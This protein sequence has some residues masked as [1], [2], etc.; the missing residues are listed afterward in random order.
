MATVEQLTSIAKQQIGNGG[1]KYRKWFYNRDTDYYGVNWCAVFISW[2]F[3]QVG[4]LN[5]YI[6][7]TDGAGSI[8]RESISAGLGGWYES[9]YSAN[10]TTPKAGDVVVFTWNGIGYMPGQDKYYSNHVGYV[11]AVDNANIYTIEGNTNSKDAD[12]SVVAYHTYNRKSG[13][14]N[15]YFRP[16]YAESEDEEVME[17]KKGCKSNAVLM[18]KSLIREAHDLGIISANCDTTDVFGDGTDKAVHEIQ[19]KYNLTVDGIAGVK[20]ITTLRNAIAEAQAKLIKPSQISGGWGIGVRMAKISLRALQAKG[21]IK[22]KP[23]AKFGYGSG[24][25]KAIKEV[26]V[27]AKITQD[28]IIGAETASAI[29]KMLIND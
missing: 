20:T 10:A 22:T 28:G 9:E 18:L 25:E 14:I 15:G 4:G 26:Q 27:A 5:K 19:K 17:F 13:C 23:D 11:Y 8:P 24:T 16:N 6:V 12:Q 29:E 21:K 1:S 2:L 3:N 7:K